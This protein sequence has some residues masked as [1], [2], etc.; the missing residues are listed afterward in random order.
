VTAST[1]DLDALVRSVL[2]EVAPDADVGSLGVDD[3][4]RDTLDLDSV[5][6]LNVMVAIHQ[7]TGIEV[8]ERDYGKLA[9]LEA[10]VTYLSG[11]R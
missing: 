9:T 4:I 3:D 6:F 11:S 1:D 10:A 5:D 8:P 7:R 2:S